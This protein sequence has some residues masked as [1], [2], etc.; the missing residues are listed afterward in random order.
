MA[1]ENVVYYVYVL[2]NEQ[3]SDE[4]YVG[5]ASDLRQRFDDHRS[6]RSVSTR[7]RAWRIAYYEAYT[8]EA[9]ARERERVLKHDGRVRRFLMD[10]LKR[11]L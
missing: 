4:F 6:G 9:A 1:L 3:Q 5:W 11:H 7:G 2:Q 10:R 8:S